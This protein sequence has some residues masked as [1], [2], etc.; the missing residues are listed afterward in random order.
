MTRPQEVWVSEL[1]REPKRKSS[2]L[3]SVLKGF[4]GLEQLECRALGT[5]DGNIRN[6]KLSDTP[7]QFT[8]KRHKFQTG[9]VIVGQAPRKV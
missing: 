9:I 4:E 7:D 3:H 5:A 2:R 1:K 8:K 6:S